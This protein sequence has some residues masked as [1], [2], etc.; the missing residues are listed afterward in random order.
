MGNMERVTITLTPEMAEAVRGAVD[1]GL[2]GLGRRALRREESQAAAAAG[3]D[4]QADV[5]LERDDAE[6]FFRFQLQDVEEPSWPFGLHDTH[7]GGQH[8]D[9][10][11]LMVDDDT[12]RMLRIAARKMKVSPAA[13]F[14]AAWAIVLSACSGRSDVVFGTLFSG[15]LQALAGAEHMLGVFINT[16]PLRVRLAGTTED[17]LINQVHTSLQEMVQFEHTPLVEALQ[18]SSVPSGI[19]LF[20]SLMNYR[21][22]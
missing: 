4:S 6:A 18:A 3:I 11:R 2:L 15:R 16:L 17:N 21:H 8:I 14:H 20:S 12:G 5:D 19:P 7:G 13:L 22:T 10:L 1:A 9:E